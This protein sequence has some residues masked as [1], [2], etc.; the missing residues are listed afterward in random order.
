VVV[1]VVKG[2]YRAV[3][4]GRLGRVGGR[5]WVSVVVA[6]RGGGG[7]LVWSA[8][9]DELAVLAPLC[10][11]ADEARLAVKY[12][13][14]VFWCDTRVVPCGSDG[15]AHV[16]LRGMSCAYVQA[17]DACFGTAGGFVEAHAVG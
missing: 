4:C 15:Q 2:L 7:R 17:G 10:Q 13:S 11:D 12:P 6:V 1:R 5:W 14:D 16:V 9:P 8:G 3:R